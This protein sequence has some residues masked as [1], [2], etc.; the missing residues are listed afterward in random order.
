MFLSGCAL[1]KLPAALQIN[2]TPSANVFVDGK[3]LGKTPYSTDTL[4]AGEVMVKLIPESATEALASWE[5]KVKL[6]GGVLTLIER[7]F[8]VS[9]NNSSGN[10]LS[11]EKAKDKNTALISIV[12]EPDG[13]FVQVD[14]EE[15]GSSPVTLD[16]ISAADHE[17]ILSKENYKEKILHVKN[18]L[19]YRLL[20]N[21]KLGQNEPSLT[22]TPT[23]SGPTPKA[24][25]TP[26][27]GG[28]ITK[29][30]FILI[31]EN[32]LGFLRVRNAP[33]G[34]EIA[35]IKPIDPEQK[36]P[37][38]EEKSGWYK[39]AYEQGKEGWVSADAIYTT[40]ITE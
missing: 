25:V 6:T 33:K 36:Y 38:L 28:K 2:S 24:T 4:K 35:Q 27:I 22:P 23:L 15:K 14:G 18:V 12:T 19:G 7:E 40:K 17:I 1:K 32:S 10:I 3:L 29:N 16:K 30:S 5:N 21:A 37:L 26:K 8:A 31:K 13:V 39:I 9:E 20:I 11:L 34:N